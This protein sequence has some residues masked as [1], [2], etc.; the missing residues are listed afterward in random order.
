M[1]R[2]SSDM[3]SPPEDS[4]AAHGLQRCD[5]VDRIVP[6]DVDALLVESDD[7][8]GD[9]VP[10]PDDEP[11]RMTGKVDRPGDELVSHVMADLR[12]EVVDVGP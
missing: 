6:G 12:R 8:L 1:M 10:V 9:P 7:A 5:G 2:G 3:R 4:D 11:A